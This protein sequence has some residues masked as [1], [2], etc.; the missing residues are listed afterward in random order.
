MSGTNVFGPGYF[1]QFSP[2]YPFQVRVSKADGYDYVFYTI[3]FCVV[4]QII[5]RQISL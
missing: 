2:I 1:F 5:A 4:F 3:A